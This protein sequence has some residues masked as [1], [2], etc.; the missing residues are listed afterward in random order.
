MNVF[1]QC[2]AVLIAAT[3][4][5]GAGV[6]EAQGTFVPT[7]AMTTPRAHQGSVVL[8]DGRVF[9]YGGIS[10]MGDILASAELYDPLTDTYAAAGAAADAR[11]RP[12][13]V[14]L[15]DGRVL[16]TGGRSGKDGSIIP[17]AVEIYDPA[18]G[19]FGPAGS[20]STPRYVGIVARL[21]DGKVLLTGG[22]NFSD[23]TLG[24]SEIYDPAAQTATPTGSLVHPRDTYGHA[25]TLADGR[26]MIV[27]GYNDDGP[28][29]TVEIYD[30]AAGTFALTGDMPDA[31]GDHCALVLADGRVLVL[32]GFGSDWNYA[33]DAYLWDPATGQFRTAGR[34]TYPRANAHATLLADGRVLVAGGS[35]TGGSDLYEPRAEIWDPASETF[36]E[37]GAMITAR[38]GGRAERLGDG[39]VLYMGGWFGD[40]QNPTG[41]SELFVPMTET[42][43]ADGFEG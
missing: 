24:S 40:G 11:M 3:G 19:T 14:G 27:G 22:F 43:F 8:A 12:T 25:L 1:K 37:T 35:T 6:A 20:V 9:Q 30:P 39:R 32:G 4:A 17:T 21:P 13:T 34:M 41:D 36:G 23:G 42:I 10:A 31:R 29:A 2:V 18:T 26:I 7:A 38:S 28:L 16:V 33:M 5:G 15:A